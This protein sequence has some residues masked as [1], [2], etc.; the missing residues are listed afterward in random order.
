MKLVRFGLPGEEQPGVWLDPAPDRSQPMILNVRAMAFD[1][2]DYN[3]H[4]FSHHGLERLTN[5]LREKN[6]KLI[7]AQGL[8]LGPPVARPGRIICLGKNY[9]DHAREFD[10]K[11]PASPILFTKANT[12]LN[13]PF[14]PIIL[15]RGAAIVDGEAEL[16]VVIGRETRQATC[17]NALEAVAGYTVLN[18][19][20][21]RT[22]QRADG[23]WFRG[24]S[25]DTFCPLGPY[26]VTHD[27]I[28]DNNRLRLISKINGVALQDGKA[29]DMIFKIPF[30]ISF[31]SATITLL[32]GDI[33]ATGTPAG[34]G[35]ARKPPIV[36][37]A[38]DVIE[39]IVE[40][41]G[42][43]IS[44]VTADQA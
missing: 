23:Q 26:L 17:E 24:K 25:P 5:L 12:A 4:F 29:A 8:R 1:I 40:G 32:P 19:V 14:D 33:I 43:Q 30:I 10:S 41:I 11:V 31:I 15:P 2:E 3:A 20:T 35:S 27:E 42:H 28:P 9:V 44:R 38:G 39:T 21:D 6:R 18:D 34:I 22:A 36:L 7:P 13:G 16:A 37:K